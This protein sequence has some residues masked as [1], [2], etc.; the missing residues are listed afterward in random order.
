MEKTPP[1]KKYRIRFLRM[2]ERTFEAVNIEA[3][4]TR[5]DHLLDAVGKFPDVRILSLE[6]VVPE[7]VGEFEVPPSPE[8]PPNGP[9]AA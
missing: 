1:M 7:F 9:R 5:A 4:R 6:E 3:A 2:I 8:L